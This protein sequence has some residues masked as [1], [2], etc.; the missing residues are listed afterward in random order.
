MYDILVTFSVSRPDVPRFQ[1]RT[2]ILEGPVVA[3]GL[4]GSPVVD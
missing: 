2:A 4:A 1:F 3:R